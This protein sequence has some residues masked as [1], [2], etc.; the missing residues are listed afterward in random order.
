MRCLIQYCQIFPHPPN[1]SRTI[2]NLLYKEGWIQ[3]LL[4]VQTAELCLVSVLFNTVILGNS[5][6]SI[7]LG[8]V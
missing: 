2:A 4:Y 8:F 5:L 7:P 1:C 3:Q 6:A